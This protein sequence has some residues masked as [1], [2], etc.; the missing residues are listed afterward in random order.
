MRA[1]YPFAG[2]FIALSLLAAYLG[3][4]SVQIP[5][6]NDKVLH[7]LAFF[8]LTLTFYW[9]FDSTRRRILNL[10][11]S[12]V[13]IF[14]GLGSEA[15]QGLLTERQFD[16]LD[17][18]ANIVGSLCALGLCSIYHKRMLDRRRRAKGYGAVPQEGD[19]IE[20]GSQE[21]GVTEDA[22]EESSQGGAGGGGEAEVNGTGGKK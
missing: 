13:T 12:F 11:V 19:D 1:R 18:A 8:V 21:T 14:L 20:M 4:S 7:F 3:L 9:I 17:I 5:Q 10:T 6:A 2:A 16:P 22:V 15:A